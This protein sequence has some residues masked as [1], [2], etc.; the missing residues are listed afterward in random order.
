MI[1]QSL[2]IT[3]KQEMYRIQ[4]LKYVSNMDIGFVLIVCGL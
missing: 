1:F 2:S 4:A 3:T